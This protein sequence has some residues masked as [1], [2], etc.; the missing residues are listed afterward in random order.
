MKISKAD[1]TGLTVVLSGPSGVGKDTVIGALLRIDA[2]VCRYVTVTTRPPREGEV[3][4][5]D[6]HF[7]SEA[8]FDRLIAE[9]RFVEWA[10]VHDH[11]YGTPKRG[12]FPEQEQAGDILLKI[13]VQGGVNVKEQMPDAVMIFLAPPS[14]KEL[15]RRLRGRHTESDESLAI[16]LQNARREMSYIVHYTYCVIN[17]TVQEAAARVQA[18]LIAERCRIRDAHRLLERLLL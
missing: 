14:L 16:R 17:D 7:I 3:P 18:I 12:V 1:S 11:R 13:D 6:Y 4:G 15:E 5:R 10:C 9:D 8:D 2:G